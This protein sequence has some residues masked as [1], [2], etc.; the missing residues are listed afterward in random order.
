MPFPATT[1]HSA[2]MAYQRVLDYAGASLRRDQL[3]SIMVSDTRLGVATF[4][5]EGLSPGFINT[6]YDC[7][8]TI[9]GRPAFPVLNSLEAPADT[10]RDGM[11]D[12][13]EKA[14]GLNPNDPADR[15]QLDENGYT[16]LEV[17]LAELVED[18]TKRQNEGGI[19]TSEQFYTPV[20]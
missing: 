19:L 11:P 16:M 5:S 15:N 4:T 8:P 18:I 3:D 10:D 7:L 20:E 13:W 1:T 14:R 6:P 9:D 12:E 17:Y 2:D